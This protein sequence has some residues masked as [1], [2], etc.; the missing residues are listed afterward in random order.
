M[1]LSVT[2]CSSKSVAAV[3]E[4]SSANI[5]TELVKEETT[6][7]KEVVK[8]DI[9]ELKATDAPEVEN[10]AD[11]KV[12]DETG[13]TN[14]TVPVAVVEDVAL[15]GSYTDST[16]NMYNYTYTLPKVQGNSEYVK[17]VNEDINKIYESVIATEL[18]N[19]DDKQSLIVSDVHYMSAEFNGITSVLIVTV[20]GWDINDY[21]VANIN[22]DGTKTEN[23]DILK[24]AGM[25]E[26]EFVN[27]VSTIYLK[28]ISPNESDIKKIDQT[29]Y[30]EIR[31]KTMAED[32]CNA[33]L[34]IYLNSVGRIAFVGKVY[35]AAGSEYSRHLFYV[36]PSDGFT[37]AELGQLARQYYQ[38]RYHLL[39]T[40]FVT[41]D[42][43][44]GYIV[45]E[46]YNDM[47]TETFF[48][49]F[50]VTKDGCGTN[51]QDQVIDITVQ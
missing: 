2:A 37:E 35:N 40:G 8:A 30:D 12:A 19:M 18:K 20:T 25:T 16:G 38:N 39:P 10:D 29:A 22:S 51:M 46:L 5:Q 13:E 6:L 47:D 50:M 26:T 21:Y 7:P 36:A 31:E 1:L 45:I 14:E 43:G 42:I 15:S 48:D 23:A 28:Q 11:D 34:P 24:A 44:D 32:N 4:M 41:E 9:E 17:E 49:Y 27:S 3:D 33:D